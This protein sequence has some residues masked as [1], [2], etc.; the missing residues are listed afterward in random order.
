MKN[1]KPQQKIEDI[2]K[3]K[4]GLLELKKQ[5]KKIKNSVNG[6]NS[7]ERTRDSE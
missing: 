3:N 2:E 7:G 4:M 1:R 6:L 5:D